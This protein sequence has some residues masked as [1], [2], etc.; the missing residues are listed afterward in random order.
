M[1]K[2]EKLIKLDGLV[3]D[4]MID[5]LDDDGDLGDMSSLTPTINYLRNNAVVADKEKGTIEKDTKK[6]LAEA[7]KRRAKG[8]ANGL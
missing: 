3:L 1:T 6:R 2:K 5:I 8:D 4:K 7:K